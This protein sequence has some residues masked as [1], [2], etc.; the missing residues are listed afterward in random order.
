MKR[1]KAEREFFSHI[2][3]KGRKIK[4]AP[5]LR[6]SGHSEYLRSLKN[7]RLGER[8]VII[9]NGPSLKETP[10]HRLKDEVTVGCNG[11]YQLFP[12]L[13]FPVT[14]YMTED[15]VQTEL[16]SREIETMR[17]P[18]KFA[19]ISNADSFSFDSDIN[20]FQTVSSWTNEDIENQ[21]PVETAFS[22][23]FDQFVVLGGTITYIMLQFAYHIGLNPVYLVGLDH[24]YGRLSQ[25]YPPGKIEITY[26]NIGIVRECHFSE[27]YYKIGDRIGVPHVALQE[28]AYKKAKRVY[29]S[30]GREIVNLSA[31]TQLD[32]FQKKEFS[33]VFD[34]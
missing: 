32:I 20:Y 16:R 23:N 31:K 29:Q 2:A 7:S 19:A 25:L 10:L 13:G 34:V 11:I 30:A 8:G 4:S 3:L 5:L 15:K 12:E 21:Q 22:T 26:E 24:S 27:E 33:K 9:A 1:R 18:L 28:A 6:I 14:Y 17:G